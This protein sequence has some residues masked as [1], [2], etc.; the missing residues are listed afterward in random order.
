MAFVNWQWKGVSNWYPSNYNANIALSAIMSVDTG[1][2]IG[3]GFARVNVALDGSGTDGIIEIGQASDVDTFLV[4]AGI[5]EYTAAGPLQMVGGGSTQ[6][7]NT[8][9]FLFT[10][11]D[12]V[13]MNYTTD[14]STDTTV[15]SFDFWWM[16]SRVDPR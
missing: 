8:G 12:T 4:A 7:V 5:D 13:D 1:T 16:I 3:P 11:A 9:M 6:Y 10:T 14:T 2:L 15:G